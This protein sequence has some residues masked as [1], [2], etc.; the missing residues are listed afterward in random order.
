[1]GCNLRTKHFWN[2]SVIDR[3]VFFDRIRIAPFHGSLNPG[4]VD[5]MNRILDEWIRSQ[6]TD[7]R[8][9]AYMLATTFHETAYTMQPIR[10]MGG[11]TYLRSKRYYP[12]VGEGLVQV[13][14]E[15]NAR[16][17]GATA[18]GQLLSWPLCLRPLFDGMTRGMFTGK[19]LADYF[20]ATTDDPV[21]ARRIIN[22][23]DRADQ[24]A[25]YHNLF[26]LSL[27]AA[28]APDKTTPQSVPD[29][30]AVT[31]A[32][33]QTPAVAPPVG[34]VQSVPVEIIT[35][36]PVLPAPPRTVWQDVWNWFF[37]KV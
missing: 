32:D 23:T 36:A 7:L 26:L 22:G 31:V 27:R 29:L 24:I 33:S 11:E 3:K 20:N 19:R 15:A 37:G 1:M 14:W 35:P 6:M 13:T 5:G 17:F 10:E 21:N 18:P 34:P 25:L 2:A 16:K 4:Q 9:L 8:F 28:Y 12:W 30:A